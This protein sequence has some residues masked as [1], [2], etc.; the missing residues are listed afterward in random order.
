M[1]L[2]LT[3]ITKFTSLICYKNMNTVTIM[4]FFLL[5]VLLVLV[6]ILILLL[7]F[8]ILS[9]ILFSIHPFFKIACRVRVTGML[10]HILESQVGNIP[11]GRTV[12]QFILLFFII[13]DL[14]LFLHSRSRPP[15]E[16]LSAGVAVGHFY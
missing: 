6:C 7:F 9:A 4:F 13:L 16:T 10:E 8:I 5:F 3:K 2:Q 12:H 11:D 14:P 1:L 15:S